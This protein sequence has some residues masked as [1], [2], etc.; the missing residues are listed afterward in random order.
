[1]QLST[2]LGLLTI[3]GDGQA[4]TAIAFDLPP[5]PAC[6]ASY[7]EAAAR[8]LAAYCAGSLRELTF[9]LAPQGTAFQKQV[10]QALREIPYG[11]TRTYGQLAAALGRP[12][13]ARAVGTAAGR[14]PCLIAIPCHR[15]VGVGGLGG[16]AA[17]LE[18]KKWLLHLESRVA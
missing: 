11:Q 10:W 9:P 13:A 8:Q 7:L 5:E 14:N 17:G 15:L 12:G 1:M 16:F 2:P 3:T 4:V 18:R 6:P